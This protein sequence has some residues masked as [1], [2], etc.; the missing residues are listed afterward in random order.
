MAS[1]NPFSYGNPISNPSRFFG[2]QQ[3]VAQVF[4]RL[5][6]PEFESSSI[7]G[8]RRTGKTSLL[9]YIS[10]PTVAERFGLDLSAHHFVYLDL[11]V[12]TPDSPTTR[13]FQHMLRRMASRIQDAEVA[14]E[15]RSAAQRETLDIYDLS[16]V[17]DLV[18]AK[19]LHIVLL[20]DEF[21]N[22]ASNRNFGPEFYYGL[23]SLAIHHNLALVTGSRLDLVELS[24]SDAVRSSPFF[25]IFATINLQP[26][27]LE[28]VHAMLRAYLE[29]TGVSFSPTEVGHIVNL[30][31]RYPFYLQMAFHF[32]FTAQQSQLPESQR[33]ELVNWNFT[34]EVHPHLDAYW[35]HSS[36]A[37]RIVLTLLSLLEEGDNTPLRT[38]RAAEL[39]RWHPAVGLVFHGLA[40]RGLVTR[41]DDRYGLL[42]KAFA[43]WV[44]REVSTPLPSTEQE[45]D[46]IQEETLAALSA[47]LRDRV[48]HWLRQTNTRYRGLFLKW[49]NDP[50][51]VEPTL[52]LLSKASGH[53]QTFSTRSL[54]LI[55]TQATPEEIVR[56][57]LETNETIAALSDACEAKDPQTRGHTVRVAELAILIGRNL[58]LPPAQLRVLGRAGL[59]HDIGKLG[60]PD[61]I[62]LKPG[63]LTP[64]E[65][66]V[67]KRHPL[68]GLDIL[69]RVGSLEQEI[70]VIRGHHEWF[71]GKGYPDGLQGEKIPLEARILS[72]A[73]VYDSV[74]S[75]RPYRKGL[76]KE[77]A[78][79]ILQE[80]AE[81][82]LDPQVVGVFIQAITQAH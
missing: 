26:F 72:V 40:R 78:I 16:D 38:W 73:D 36:D 61:A 5:R 20:L 6:N 69:R 63:P 2:R 71:N 25:N 32:L 50:R 4:S 27:T 62:L 79:K 9:N 33:L 14:A 53:F 52:E 30:V 7:V 3:E 12:I 11:E 76:G 37:E 57:E 35:Q 41:A 64:E 29:G 44:L 28:D 8:E 56:A 77:R 59:L 24:H 51:V 17:F 42:S 74:I 1:V 34:E 19:G 68:L 15:L 10:H 82:H 46:Q 21:E 22:I 43:R 18:D 47:P 23:R 65:F 66:G 58:G 67:M 39:E 31:G 75:D 55:E 13:F 54:R 60:V 80:E 48:L 45:A 49:L 81:Q 70:G